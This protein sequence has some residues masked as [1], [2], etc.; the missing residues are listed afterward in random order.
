M[1][2]ERFFKQNKDITNI[3]KL[4]ILIEML[5]NSGLREVLT[6]ICTKTSILQPFKLSLCTLYGDHTTLP[7]L[8]L[9]NTEELYR[10]FIAASSW[11]SLHTLHEKH[12]HL[13]EVDMTRSNSIPRALSWSKL[14]TKIDRIILPKRIKAH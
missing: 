11:K 10:D 4:S 14:K 8:N 9:L 6:L 2:H 1:S 12:N 5:T 13:F 3:C 7:Q